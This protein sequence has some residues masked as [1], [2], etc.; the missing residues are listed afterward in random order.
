MS[1]A[2][3]TTSGD[4]IAQVPAWTRWLALL[5]V[6]YNGAAAAHTGS[7][8]S[9]MLA[10]AWSGAD[11]LLS[12]WLARINDRDTATRERCARALVL[13]PSRQPAGSA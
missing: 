9:L 4:P 13:I 10:F 1:K 11:V 12:Q 3:L 8:S 6:F 2:N 7:E 5:R